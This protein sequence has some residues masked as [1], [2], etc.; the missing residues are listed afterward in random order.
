MAR[1]RTPSQRRA[2]K[3]RK[4]QEWSL[5]HQQALPEHLR[6]PYSIS[7]E[8]KSW[9]IR[10]HEQTSNAYGLRSIVSEMMRRTWLYARSMPAEDISYFRFECGV[11][12]TDNYEEMIRRSCNAA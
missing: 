9:K 11:D 12:C 2:A 6:K 5:L 1:K 3:H 4:Q 7:F 10:S 8:G